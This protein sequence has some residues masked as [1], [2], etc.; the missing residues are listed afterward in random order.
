MVLGVSLR[1]A[2]RSPHDLASHNGPVLVL[3]A[4]VFVET[5]DRY[6]E[7]VCEL[8]LIFNT[9]KVCLLLRITACFTCR[10]MEI[11]EGRHKTM[12]NLA[13]LE[14]FECT[15]L[16]V[17]IASSAAYFQTPMA[18]LQPMCGAR[19]GPESNWPSCTPPHGISYS[20]R[21]MLCW[22]RW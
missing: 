9:E 8:D 22:T 6:F 14:N 5:L 18:T 15:R 17:G 13:G 3:P 4:Q 12:F 20:R 21:C 1:S 7:N 19:F 11:A 16:P 10:Q 2:T